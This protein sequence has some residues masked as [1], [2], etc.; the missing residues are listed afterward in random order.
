ML[1]KVKKILKFQPIIRK[2][3]LKNK[4]TF[5][6]MIKLQ[7]S[8]CFTVNVAILFKKIQICQTAVGSFSTD[9]APRV[10]FKTLSPFLRDFGSSYST[11]FMHLFLR[12]S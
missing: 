11:S 7:I 6:L 12:G 10:I 2:L 4:S 9:Y 8:R 5:H 1:S 3:N